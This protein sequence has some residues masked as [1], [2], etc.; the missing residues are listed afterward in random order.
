[1]TDGRSMPRGSVGAVADGTE[2]KN[3]LALAAAEIDAA[4]GIL[5]RTLGAHVGTWRCRAISR[6]PRS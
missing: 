5:G 3:G 2:F 4:G 6:R 1:M